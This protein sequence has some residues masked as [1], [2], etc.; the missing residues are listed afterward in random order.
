V[1][2]VTQSALAADAE[3]VAQHGADD[4][5]DPVAIAVKH[6]QRRVRRIDDVHF[7][8]VEQRLG[9]RGGHARIEEH[10]LKLAEQS[11]RLRVARVQSVELGP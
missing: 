10:R 9:I 1:R 4:A 7:H 6:C 5:R 3:H 11:A 2:R 8:A